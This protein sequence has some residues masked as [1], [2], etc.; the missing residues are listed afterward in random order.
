[1]AGVVAVMTRPSAPADAMKIPPDCTNER[2]E[3]GMGADATRNVIAA[4]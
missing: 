1:M 4:L 3:I 2:R